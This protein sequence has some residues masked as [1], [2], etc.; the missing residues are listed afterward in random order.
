[1]TVPRAPDPD[2]VARILAARAPEICDYV[3][4]HEVLQLV[5]EVIDA[6]E[7]RPQ[8]LLEAADGPLTF[9]GHQIAKRPRRAS[10]GPVAPLC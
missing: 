2:Y 5:V 10:V 7:A 9:E 1:M 4:T 8:A 3:V 6:Q